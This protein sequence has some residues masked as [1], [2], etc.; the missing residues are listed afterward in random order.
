MPENLLGKT[1]LSVDIGAM[2]AGAKYRGEFEE[3]LKRLT[4]EVMK[5][6][7]TILL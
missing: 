2:I 5:N 4:D 7:N 1:V 6:R 3:R